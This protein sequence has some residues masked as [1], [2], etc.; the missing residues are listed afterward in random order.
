MAYSCKKDGSTIFHVMIKWNWLTVKCYAKLL[1]VSLCEF[2][3]QRNG[4]KFVSFSELD[5][6]QCQRSITLPF[7]YN[8]TFGWWP[9][10]RNIYLWRGFG[11]GFSSKYISTQNNFHRINKWVRKKS[12]VHKWFM[13]FMWFTTHFF[14][15]YFLKKKNSNEFPT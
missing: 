13:F 14:P 4:I 2:H 5:S 8:I 6:I 11:M 15:V 7:F 9:R 12:G 1:W 3:F 10:I